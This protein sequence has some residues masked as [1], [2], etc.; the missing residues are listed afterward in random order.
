MPISNTPTAELDGVDAEAADELVVLVAAERLGHDVREHVLCR[1][2]LERDVVGHH[3]LA[4]E[5]MAAV[6]EMPK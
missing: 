5:V 3:L 6:H 4:D 1:H 2:V